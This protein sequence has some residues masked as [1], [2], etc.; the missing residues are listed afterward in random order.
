MR[1]NFALQGAQLRFVGHLPQLFGAGDFQLGGDYLRQANRH[2]L[3]RR[4]DA[5]GVAVIDFSVPVTTPFS[6]SGITIK[7]WISGVRWAS[8]LF[9]MMIFP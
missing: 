1:V 9:F 3:Q 6:H 5:M 2:L 4:S 7:E 8:S